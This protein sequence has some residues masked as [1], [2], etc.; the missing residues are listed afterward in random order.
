MVRLSS[1]TC[2][3]L[4]C[5]RVSRPHRNEFVLKLFTRNGSPSITYYRQNCLEGN[6]RKANASRVR[7]F[8][9]AA[10][11]TKNDYGL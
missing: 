2:P 1:S 8:D 10:V 11:K 5:I 4:V 6:Y 7:L 9:Q 3:L